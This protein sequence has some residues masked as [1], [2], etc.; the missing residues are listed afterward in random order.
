MNERYTFGTGSLAAER[1]HVL[2]RVFEPTMAALLDAAGARRADRV[3]DLGCGPGSS[4]GS[5]VRLVDAG[6]VTGLDGSAAF[7][8]EA[9][10]RLP[11]ARF[12]NADVTA[13]WPVEPPDLAYA[14][15]LLAHL[16]TPTTAV[17][18]WRAQLAPAGLLLL[19]ELE[20][21]ET[22]IDAYRRYLGI[23]T[24][25]V[26]SRGASMYAGRA[27]RDRFP[28]ALVDRAF[29]LD[30]APVD[31]SAMFTMN[32]ASWREDPW[33]TAH[34]GAAEL[35][36][37]AGALRAA[38]SGTATVRWTVRQIALRAPAPGPTGA[39]AS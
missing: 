12:V 38:A 17:G 8:A 33:I 34:L 2:A 7:L 29:T 19:E 10:T 23:T 15:F 5:L 13:P 28:G 4:T 1:L 16:P 25:L 14:R 24:A 9:V 37:L 11:A 18:R 20:N 36:E 35:D 21:I 31:A 32:L 27:L 6:Q 26:A 30:V 3:V 39:V 22:G